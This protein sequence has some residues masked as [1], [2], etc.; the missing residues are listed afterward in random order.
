MG[1]ILF[2]VCFV[3]RMF[4]FLQIRLGKKIKEL[5]AKVRR[6]SKLVDLGLARTLL[7]RSRCDKIAFTLNSQVHTN[8]ISIE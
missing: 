3:S 5:L 2:L 7:S 6:G 8:G 1:E 4:H